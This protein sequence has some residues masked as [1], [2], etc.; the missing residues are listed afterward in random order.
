MAGACCFGVN[1]WFVHVRRVVPSNCR[2]SSPHRV[3]IVTPRPIRGSILLKEWSHALL[4][5]ALH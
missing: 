4:V 2:P 1:P 3:P 5:A